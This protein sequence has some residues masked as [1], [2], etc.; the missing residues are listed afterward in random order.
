MTHSRNPITLL[1][2]SILIAS[3]MAC[4]SNQGSSQS[5]RASANTFSFDRNQRKIDI[6]LDATITGWTVNCSRTHAIVWGKADD[7][8]E[9]GAP[10]ATRVY[11][12][13]IEHD[14]PINQYTVTRGPYEVIFSQDLRQA[15]VDDYVIDQNSGEIVGMTEDINLMAESCPSFPDKQLN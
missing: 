7:L 9:V 15:S 12:V 4:A 5:F 14:K 3:G 10:P 11:V 13:D 2:L 6:R 8:E 1:P